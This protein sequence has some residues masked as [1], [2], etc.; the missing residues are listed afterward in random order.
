MCL[1]GV[2][3]QWTFTLSLKSQSLLPSESQTLFNWDICS[4]EVRGSMLARPGVSLIFTEFLTSPHESFLFPEFLWRGP[5]L[6][7]ELDQT[8]IPDFW[9]VESTWESSGTTCCCS[10][11]GPASPHF[12]SV[13]ASQEGR[14]WD[15]GP[16][17]DPTQEDSGPFTLQILEMCPEIKCTKCKCLK[18]CWFE[19][20]F[21]FYVWNEKSYCNICN[22]FIGQK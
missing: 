17:T 20:L 2:G 8:L 10:Q 16:R 21:F 9:L 12:Y 13:A 4:Q 1:A 5:T 11:S 7:L 15:Y 6:S 14:R 22:F 3:P 19:W 18:A